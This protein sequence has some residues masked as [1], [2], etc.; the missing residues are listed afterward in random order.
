MLPFVN[1][2]S[3]LSNT[4]VKTFVIPSS[5]LELEFTASRYTL[6]EIENKLF[7]SFLTGEVVKLHECVG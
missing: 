3:I 4:F 5:M 2:L 7:V 1:P 6:A